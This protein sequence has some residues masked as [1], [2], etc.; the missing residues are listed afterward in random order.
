[1]CFNSLV[2]GKNY[3]I[4]FKQESRTRYNEKFGEAQAQT[5]VPLPK[6]ALQY[7][8]E[9]S[10]E[11]GNPTTLPNSS[12]Y[13]INYIP[14]SLKNSNLL[15]YNRLAV[16]LG[17]VS[18]WRVSHMAPTLTRLPTR[19]RATI[20]LSLISDVMSEQ[21]H[22]S[23]TAPIDEYRVLWTTVSECL[24]SEIPLLVL[25]KYYYEN[26]KRSRSLK[27]GTMVC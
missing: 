14:G 20:A 13:S 17:E 3:I 19:W 10:T 25:T 27:S 8:D 9:V 7:R 16:G 2:S 15:M 1:M 5:I 6:C 12:E 21:P 4:V 26:S 24:F 23:Q 18:L 11:S 22:S